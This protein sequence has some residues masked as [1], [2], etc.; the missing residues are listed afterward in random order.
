MVSG[1]LLITF[2]IGKL[3][4][5][6]GTGFAGIAVGFSITATNGLINGRTHGVFLDLTAIEAVSSQQYLRSWV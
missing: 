4:N 6:L 5:A 3:Q 2:P 1:A